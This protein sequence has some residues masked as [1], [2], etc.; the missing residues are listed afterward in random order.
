MLF[1]TEGSK[2]I[3]LSGANDQ[4]FSTTREKIYSELEEK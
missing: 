3:V 2:I 1:S 4:N